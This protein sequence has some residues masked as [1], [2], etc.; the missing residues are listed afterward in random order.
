[1]TE[2]DRDGLPIDWRA[3]E[4][5]LRDHWADPQRIRVTAANIRDNAAPWFRAALLAKLAQTVW[6]WAPEAICHLPP[7]LVAYVERAQT[8]GKWGRFSLATE[9]QT[10]AI[11]T[12]ATAKPPA[13]PLDDLDASRPG[14]APDDP[15]A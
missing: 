5:Y 10:H 13:S 8:S 12:A 4:R 14:P 11:Q 1:M 7:D 9:G 15:T 3:R 6:Q 2:L